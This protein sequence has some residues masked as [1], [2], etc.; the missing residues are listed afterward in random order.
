MV[1][2]VIVGAVWIVVAFAIVVLRGPLFRMLYAVDSKLNRR[3][4]VRQQAHSE[5]LAEWLRESSQDK[6]GE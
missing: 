6:T 4:K 5:A 2:G 3:V 1:I